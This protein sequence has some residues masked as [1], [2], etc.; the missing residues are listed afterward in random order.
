RRSPR[1]P[2]RG[3]HVQVA[4]IADDHRV[5]P[6]PHASQEPGL[7]AREPERRA[8]ARRPLVL[9]TVPYGLVPLDDL[10]AGAAQARDHLGVPRVAALVRPEVENPHDGAA[11]SGSYSPPWVAAGSATGRPAAARCSS[12]TASAR[13]LPSS[14]SACWLVIIS[15][16]SPSERNWIPTTISSTPRIRSGRWPIACPSTLSIVR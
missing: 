15:L 13:A 4:G 2:S 10:D 12:T 6:L 1:R 8:R 3:G 11:R 16:I 9:A 7:R 14:R 5:E